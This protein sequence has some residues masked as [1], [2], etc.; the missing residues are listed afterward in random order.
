MPTIDSLPPEI[1]KQIKAQLL[2]QKI[3]SY[4]KKEIKVEGRVYQESKFNNYTKP[5]EMIDFKSWDL[6][7]GTYIK[8]EVYPMRG[9]FDAERVRTLTEFKKLIPVISRTFKGG[10]FSKLISFLY[11][12]KNWRE[13][14]Y[15]I[16]CGMRDLHL[17]PKYFSQPV[18]EVYRV[19]EDPEIRDIICEVLEYD[20]AYRY[21]FQ[22]I[23]AEL[24][25][26][27][28]NENPVKELKR[29]LRIAFGRGHQGA[30][31]V[32]GKIEHIM[33]LFFL[34]LRFNGKLAKKIKKYI[35]ELNIDEIKLS[36]EDIYWTNWGYEEYDFRGLPH[37]ERLKEYY[38]IKNKKHV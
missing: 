38:S 2:M 23:F 34:Y 5:K 22:D 7:C 28:F 4:G 24:D 21:R 27:S 11:L 10:L 20:T 13:Y 17:E 16:H 9:N 25:K 26:E 35:N 6:G 32:S 14:T 1:Q 29:L 36:P 19:I 37:E 15:F 30:D 12:K 31:G 3:K 33:P 8:D 18:R